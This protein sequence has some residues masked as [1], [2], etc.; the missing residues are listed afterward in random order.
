[1]AADDERPDDPLGHESLDAF[2][3][4]GRPGR[5]H[6]EALAQRYHHR[7]RIRPTDHDDRNADRVKP[8]NISDARN[9]HRREESPHRFERLG[10]GHKS[11]R[12][13]PVARRRVRF[14]RHRPRRVINPASALGF[15][16]QY[17]KQ[18][19]GSPPSRRGSAEYLKQIGGFPRSRCGSAEYLKQIGG[20]PLE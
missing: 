14:V 7:P 11:M 9:S 8:G 17:A 13:G 19:P 3:D 2:H 18:M 5:H 1:V 16:D 10:R 6:I 4:T 20:S 15:L 12:P